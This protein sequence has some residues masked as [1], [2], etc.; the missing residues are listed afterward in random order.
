MSTAPFS[1]AS[2]GH[3]GSFLLF[4][5]APNSDAVFS[6]A[7]VTSGSSKGLTPST[8]PAPL[9]Q[10]STPASTK[11]RSTACPTARA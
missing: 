10:I 11:P 3:S 5:H 9:P 8:T 2:A 4:F 7:R 1:S 6:F